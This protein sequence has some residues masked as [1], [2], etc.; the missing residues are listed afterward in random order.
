MSGLVQHRKVLAGFLFAL[1]LGWGG[2]LGAQSSPIRFSIIGASVTEK[3]TFTVTLRAD[4]L[5]TG[6]SVFAYRFYLSY[7]P[8]YL[9]FLE[10]QGTGTVLAGWGSPAVN[11]NNAGTLIMAGAGSDALTGNGD[12]IT[13]RFRAI[14]SGT[15]YLTF[16]TGESYLNEGNPPSIY[17]NGTISAAARSYPNIYPDQQ[18]LFI[19]NEVKMSVSGGLAPFVFSSENPSLVQVSNEDT[20]RAVGPG[21]TRITVTDANGET[22]T[23]TGLF[24]VRAV[25]LDLQ[26]VSAWPADTFYIPVKLEVAPGT[27]IVSG[28]FDLTF[29]GGLSALPEDFL[30]GDFPVVIDHNARNGRVSVS[31]ATSSGI[32]GS[33]VLCYLPF[34]ANSSGNQYVQ[35]E[36]MRFNETLLALTVKSYYY[37]LVNSLPT[38]SFS[39]N[40][41]TLA[42]GESL[43]I[44]VYNGTAPYAWTISDPSVASIDQQ[45]NL[46]AIT[47]GKV[48]VTATDDNGATRTTGLFTITD[49][50]VSIF[51]TDGVLDTDTRVPLVT[52]SLSSGKA[53]YGFRARVS[54]DPTYLD[55]VRA[56]SSGGGLIQSSLS[57][58]SVDLAGA[59]GQGVSSGIVGY[60]VFRIKTS[61]AL[62]ASTAVT[63]NSFSANENSLYSTFQ[64]GSVHRVEQASYR[65]VAIAGLDFSLE[66]GS[67]GQLDGSASFDLDNDPM[68]FRWTAPTGIVLSDSTSINPAFTAPFVSKNT[69][70]TFRLIANDGKDD[71]DPSFV[72]V[73]VLQVNQKP[74]ASAGADLSY[75]E[76]SSVSLDGSASFD[77][78]GDAISYSWASLDG[79]VLF[80]AASVSPSFILPQV[81]VNTSYRFTLVV[82]D[83]SLTSPRDTV[84]ITAIQVNKKPVA[85][86]GGDFSVDEGEPAMLDGSL[87]YDAD[88]DPLTYMWT[89]P[90]QVTLSSTTVSQPAF[91]APAAHRD[92]V[93]TFILVVNDGTRDSDPD[94]VKVTIVNL[95]SLSMEALIDSVFMAELDSSF[96][97]TA[98]SAVS[99]YLSY[100][101]DTRSL[102]PGFTVSKGASIS[103]ASG[104]THD[105]S[106]PVYYWVMAEDG[107]TARLWKV[108][109]FRPL[110]TVQRAL[111]SGW[112]WISLNVRPPDTDIGT[113]FG[114]LSLSD[115][116]YVKSTEYSSTWYTA[117]GWFGNLVVFPQ[118]RVVRFKK[119]LPE[120]LDVTGLEINPTITPVPLVKG[121]NDLAYLLRS[122]AP[123]DAAIQTTSIP[124]GDVLLKGLEGSAVYYAGSGWTGELDT[125]KVLHGYKLNVQSPGNLYYNPSAAKKSSPPAGYSRQKL[126]REYSI[127]PQDYEYSA[128]LIAEVTTGTGE[129]F[130]GPGDL[131][132]AY[133]GDEIRGV[134][135]ARYVPALE[136]YLF[137]LTYYSGEEDQ[138]INFRFRLEGDLAE[139]ASDLRLDF[140]PDGITGEAYKPYEIVMSGPDLE[141]GIRNGGRFSAYPNPVSDLLTVSSPEPLG[142]IRIY[143]VTGATILELFGKD[144]TITLPLGQ[145]APGIYTLEAETAGGVY[146]RKIIKTSY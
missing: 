115:L 11:S 59:F 26:E 101:T 99:L 76:G 114:S 128:T 64:S 113:L 68:T 92:T 34:R 130:A 138:E 125:L 104:S 73:T 112:N 17:T 16:N 13:L 129:S 36:N 27:Q 123:P 61:L 143:D 30:P 118:N 20:V 44:N 145:L 119:G 50:Q 46:T 48:S 121:W 105:L 97:D 120:E 24:D 33:G 63:L 41:G 6:R 72:H 139:Y 89:A 4:S 134:T 91:T 95:D 106:L 19:G 111:S 90:P 51:P 108:E 9:E 42:W 15:T 144:K 29:P 74:S 137:I 86:A 142:K 7:S 58:S 96:I 127:S 78:D 12:M 52:S 85:Y 94:Q 116:D 39:P 110:K 60:V 2:N 136:K 80:N 135:R 100:G 62:D 35:F 38:L 32:S 133:H 98:N 79:I 1:M 54:F 87:S 124:A 49:N 132:L 82:S 53:I 102:A 21:T 146:V 3:D 141:H 40:S 81:T 69:V 75:I 84:T 107:I 55:F 88:N 31:F 37:I 71:S 23:T 5:L 77:P 43:K 140:I 66:E 109:V 65:P 47:G 126:L 70:Y 56:E 45:G 67:A 22:S 10:I 122:D 18:V 8:T 131:L 25:K 28:R 117:T 103:P 14:R 57:G 93:L 83:G